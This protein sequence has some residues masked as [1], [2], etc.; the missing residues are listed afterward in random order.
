[1][2]SIGKSLESLTIEVLN[3]GDDPGLMSYPELRLNYELA[4]TLV[5]LR[6][7]ECIFNATYGILEV[8]M[9]ETFALYPVGPVRGMPFRP[10]FS[11]P[12]PNH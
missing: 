5:P 1:M 11:L 6:L 12:F 2:K 9:H 4:V 8:Q 3:W 10:S 7:L